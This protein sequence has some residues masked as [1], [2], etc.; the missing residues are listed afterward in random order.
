MTTEPHTEAQAACEELA[1]ALKQ[2][3]IVLPSLGVDPIWLSDAWPRA[4][5]ELGRC[6]LETAHRLIAVLKRAA[7]R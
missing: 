3:G 4:L 2:V 5:V 6:N 1:A 7:E